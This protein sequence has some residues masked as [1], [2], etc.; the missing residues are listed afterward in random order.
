M[1]RTEP[2]LMGYYKLPQL[3]E[4]LRAFLLTYYILTAYDNNQAVG[5]KCQKH[6]RLITIYIIKYCGMTKK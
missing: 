4:N 5:N 3:F 2:I 1:S 6:W